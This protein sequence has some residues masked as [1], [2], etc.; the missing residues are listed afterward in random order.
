MEKYQVYLIVVN[1]LSFLFCYLFFLIGSLKIKKY[2]NFFTLFFSLLGATFGVLL[3]FVLFDRKMTKENA[4]YLIFIICLFII[5]LVIYLIFNKILNN[6][7]FSSFIFTRY[8]WSYLLLI[9]IVSFFI[10]G[11]DKYKALHNKKRI[12]IV[13]LFILAF[14]GGSLG[15]MFAMYLFRHKTNKVYFK[16]GIPL[17]LVTQF[18]VFFFFI[19]FKFF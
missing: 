4:L 8:F 3:F 16:Y 18:T 11:L 6:I 15:S 12:K 13:T 14:L 5:Q 9:N 1:S 10:Y 7:Y 2:L 17:I 19:S